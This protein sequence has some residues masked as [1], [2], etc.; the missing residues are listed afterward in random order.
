MFT[1]ATYNLRYATSTSDAA[2][3]NRQWANRR[4]SARDAMLAMNAD[5][6]GFQEVSY[7]T[8]PEQSQL[9]DLLGLVTAAGGGPWDQLVATRYIAAA[10]RSDKFTALTP[11]TTIDINVDITRPGQQRVLAWAK[12]REIA[13]GKDFLFAF[14]HFQHNDPDL[15]TGRAMRAESAQLVSNYMR[16]LSQSNGNIPFV[17][18]ADFNDASYAAG[19][20]YYLMAQNG[21]RNSRTRATSLTNAWLNS[22]SGFDAN[23]VGKQSGLWIDGVLISDGWDVFDAGMSVQFASGSAPPLKV[24]IGSDHMPVWARLDFRVPLPDSDYGLVVPFSFEETVASGYAYAEVTGTATPEAEITIQGPVTNPQIMHIETG[25]TMRFQTTIGA[26]ETL[27]INLD[28]RTVLADGVSSRRG[29]MRGD[30]IALEHGTNSLAF[31][32]ESEST[33][34]RMTVTWRDAYL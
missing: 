24:P 9:T 20:V 8:F 31:G 30:W 14:T 33:D 16:S 10:Y 4:T 11:V 18:T 15:A 2:H 12:M 5:I 26:A 25:K 29:T 1:A 28:A 13:S 19:S 6:V 7:A 17:V 32:A 22:Y 34:A 23:M 27:V 21:I 3:P